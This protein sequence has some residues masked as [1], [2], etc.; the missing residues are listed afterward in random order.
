MPRIEEFRKVAY[1]KGLGSKFD[2]AKAKALT[3]MGLGEEVARAEAGLCPTCGKVIEE[4]EFRDE[5][6]KK[7]YSISRMCQECQDCIFGKES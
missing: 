6:S 4:G 2:E 3:F 5:K 1:M 7:E